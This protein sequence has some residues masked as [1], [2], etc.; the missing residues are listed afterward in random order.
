M[1]ATFLPNIRSSNSYIYIYSQNVASVGLLGMLLKT[2]M[3]L[4]L[5][6]EKLLLAIVIRIYVGICSWPFWSLRTHTYMNK[7]NIYDRDPKKGSV[8]TY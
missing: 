2:M 6:N 5:L 3:L 1:I 7:K 8:V 4:L